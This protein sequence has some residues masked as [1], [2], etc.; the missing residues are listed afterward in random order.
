MSGK[1]WFILCGKKLN[2]ALTLYLLFLL[3]GI[4]KLLG[5]ELFMSK[6]F[7]FSALIDVAVASLVHSSLLLFLY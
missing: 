5:L 2:V 6:F 4:Q 7:M 1:S 3:R